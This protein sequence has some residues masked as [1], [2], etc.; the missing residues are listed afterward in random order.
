MMN[1]SRVGTRLWITLIL[2][3]LFGQLAWVIENM[4]FN[5]FLYN[6]ISGDPKAI[7]WMV[8]ASAITAT[9][10]TIFMGALSDRISKRKKFMSIGYILWGLTT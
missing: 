2:F 8:A 9:L 1:K 6:K 5:L 10:T 3:G 4:Y 7:A